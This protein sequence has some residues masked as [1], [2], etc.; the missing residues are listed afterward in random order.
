MTSESVLA[1][2]AALLYDA[3]LVNPDDDR[4]GR[5]DFARHFANAIR[6][7]DATEGFVFALSG[8]WGAGKTSILNFTRH[9]LQTNA[10]AK[11]DLLLVD[12]NPWWFSGRDD[13]EGVCKGR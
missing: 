11:D 13:L 7:L 10:D 8:P 12:F 2:S 4:L 3:P 6:N 9:D 1:P 5:R